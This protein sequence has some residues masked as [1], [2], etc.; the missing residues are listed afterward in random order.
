MTYKWKKNYEQFCPKFKKAGVDFY[1]TNGVKKNFWG[2][3]KNFQGVK[4]NSNFFP[5]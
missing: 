5:A 4:K 2:V 1:P 3:K